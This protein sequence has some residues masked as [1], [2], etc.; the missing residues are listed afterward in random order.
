VY[1]RGFLLPLLLI[2]IGV[3]AFFVNIGVFDVRVLLRLLNLWPLILVL[4][5]VELIITRTLPRRAVPAVSLLVLLVVV[6]AAIVFVI[7]APIGGI[8][9]TQQSVASDRIDGLSAANLELDFGAA[10]VN[11]RGGGLG[12]E[13]YR[14]RFEFSAAEQT[15]L[16]HLDRSSGTLRIEQ[17]QRLP[18]I[19]FGLPPDRDR[20]D[21][22][23]TDRIPWTVRLHG[24]ALRSTLDL[25]GL[26]TSKLQLSGGANTTDITLRAPKGLVAVVI[27]GGATSVTLHIPP[28][29]AAR[30][31]VTGGAS[32]L[33]VDGS[34]HR[35]IGDKPWETEGYGQAADRFD[36]RV[37]GGATHARLL[38]HP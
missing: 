28:G 17:Q 7:L 11:L 37:S 15:P 26:D 32:D 2:V 34:H 22:S 33:E 35:G 14:G 13:L 36:I 19:T 12:D 30:V 27:S 5:G 3:V 4:L 23:L 8:A 31:R 18:R 29:S 9:G 21:L 38:T 16:V 10:E 20:V 25:G 6:V 1:R 24:G